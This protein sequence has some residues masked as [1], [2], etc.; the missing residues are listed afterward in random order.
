L[1]ICNFG[2]EFKFKKIKIKILNLSSKSRKGTKQKIVDR[3][4]GQN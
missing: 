3:H 2:F 4:N 1:N